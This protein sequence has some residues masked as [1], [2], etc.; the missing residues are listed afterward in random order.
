MTSVKS[1]KSLKLIAAGAVLAAAA[2]GV[3]YLLRDKRSEESLSE[4]FEDTYD[5][6]FEDFEDEP[7]DAPAPDTEG[8]E[9]NA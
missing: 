2:A 5:D 7:Q 6:D 3:Q 4:D 1:R 8:S 9:E